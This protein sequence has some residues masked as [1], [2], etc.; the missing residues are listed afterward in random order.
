MAPGSG[1]QVNALCES[2]K[3]AAVW[4]F[5]ALIGHPLDI[6]GDMGCKP[7]TFH[8]RYGIVVALY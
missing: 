2:G 7:Q 5:V 8:D 3:G 6:P 4:V 1:E